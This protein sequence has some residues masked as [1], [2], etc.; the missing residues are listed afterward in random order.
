MVS[1]TSRKRNK[2]CEVMGTKWPSYRAA[3]AKAFLWKLSV[4]EV[5]VCNVEN[6][7][8]LHLLE[9][10]VARIIFFP[11]LIDIRNC[12]KYKHTTPIT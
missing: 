10:H 11:N 6:S 3:S 5:P 2:V 1:Q 9:E 7:G 12:S 8:M 4:Q